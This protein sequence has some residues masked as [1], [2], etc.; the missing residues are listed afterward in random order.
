MMNIKV[1]VDFSKSPGPR[2]RYR[3]EGQSACGQGRGKAIQP[4]PDLHSGEQFRT[5]LLLPRIEDAIRTGQP[6]TVDLDGT[7]GFGTSFLEEAFG[8]LI[9]ENGIPVGDVRSVLTVVSNEE[10]ELLEEIDAY[11]DDAEGMRVAKE[12]KE[13]LWKN[14]KCNTLRLFP[15]KSTKSTTWWSG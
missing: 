6:L 2:Y 1:S 15:S 8:G 9:R 5:E 3:S 14:W 11:M 10:P 4:A 12:K 7:F 13:K